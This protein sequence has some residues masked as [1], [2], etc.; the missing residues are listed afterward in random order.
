MAAP[1]GP[2]RPENLI[3]FPAAGFVEMVLEAGTQLFEGKSFVV[4][5]FEIRKPLILPDPPSGLLL[6]LTYDPNERTFALQSR[7]ENGA[8]WS[9]HVVGSMRGERTESAF[10]ASMWE[11]SQTPGLEAVGLDTFYGHMSDLGLCYGEEFRPIRELSAG[12]GRSAGRVSLSDA[13]A[14]RAGEYPL[15]P[16]LFDG[17]LQIFSAGAARRLRGRTAGLEAPFA[18]RQNF[19]S[20]LSRGLQLRPGRCEAGQRRIRRRRHLS[21]DEA[22][23]A[24]CPH[25]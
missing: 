10:A 4:E 16:V 21:Y 14:H 3:V 17:A 23:R 11:T 19:V 5:D 22:V 6:E 13:I 9:V 7:F 1:E 8:S 20:S 18:L 25:R 12:A 24:L 15:H 2:P